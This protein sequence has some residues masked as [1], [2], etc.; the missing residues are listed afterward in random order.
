VDDTN[1]VQDILWVA[2][3]LVMVSG[4]ARTRMAAMVLARAGAQPHGRHVVFRAASNLVQP[5][6]RAENLRAGLKT[7]VTTLVA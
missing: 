4:I 5:T 1:G 6:Q 7:E 3:G 2:A